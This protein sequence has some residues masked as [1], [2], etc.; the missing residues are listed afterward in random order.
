M[1]V[2]VS[3]LL[4]TYYPSLHNYKASMI[5]QKASTL[6]GSEFSDIFLNV[7]GQRPE[8]KVFRKT[9]QLMS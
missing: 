3:I 1:C 4:D 9:G 5:S 7:N 2:C 8:P 6:F